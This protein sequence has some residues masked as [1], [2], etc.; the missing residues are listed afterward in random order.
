VQS[1]EFLIYRL[2]HA[3]QEAV[4]SWLEDNQPKTDETIF[5]SDRVGLESALLS[6]DEPLVKLGLALYG[7]EQKTGSELYKRSDELLKKAV[8]SGT[9]IRRSLIGDSWV[10]SEGIMTEL[11]DAKNSGLLGA[12]LSNPFVD[13]DLLID[14]YEKKDCF[15]ILCDEFWRE[16][17]AHTL[18]NI[19]LSTPYS[20]RWMDG[21]TDY[22]YT[23]VFSAGW[24]FFEKLPVNDESATLLARLGERMV[25][26]KPHDMAV[27]KVIERWKKD[28]SVDYYALCRTA[29]VPDQ[30]SFDKCGRFGAP[31]ETAPK[32]TLLICPHR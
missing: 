10:V 2:T 3:S 22:L 19:R 18:T 28:N 31:P 12:L 30:I 27:A 6:R 23:R 11:L 29:L 32:D 14:L 1:Q 17:I 21:W 20:E 24:K 13:D 25:P 4:Y 5:S 26:H 8:L 16:L 9:T 7:Y 15:E